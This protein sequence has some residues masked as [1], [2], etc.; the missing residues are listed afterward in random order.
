MRSMYWV[1]VRTEGWGAFMSVVWE[2]KAE[3]HIWTSSS[4]GREHNANCHD[5]YSSPNMHNTRMIKWRRVRWVMNVAHLGEREMHAELIRQSGRRR[6]FW[7]TGHSR[8]YNIK[9]H[10]KEN[11]GRDSIVGIATHCGL[12]GPGIE[13]QWGRDFPHPSRP[14]LRPTQPAVWWVPGL[15]SKSKVARAWNCP[16]IPI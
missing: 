10:Y 7:R 3:E 5:L 12:D 9:M 2:Q 15:F 8:K 14:P 4:N 13:S 1:C 16:P 11:G 6:P